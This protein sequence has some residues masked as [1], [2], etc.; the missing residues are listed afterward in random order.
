MRD[1][2]ALKVEEN[3]V[4]YATTQHDELVKVISKSEILLD[5]KCDE[6]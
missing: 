5:A 6:I 2:L 1:T 4:K 3:S